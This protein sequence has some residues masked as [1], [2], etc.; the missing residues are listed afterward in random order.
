[1]KRTRQKIDCSKKCPVE[2]ALVT[3]LSLVPILAIVT[4]GLVF[5]FC[6]WAN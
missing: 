5:T 4:K 3:F 6:S 2:L 1:M